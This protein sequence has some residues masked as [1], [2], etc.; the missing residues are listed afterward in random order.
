MTAHTFHRLAGHQITE[1]WPPPWT[2]WI[3]DCGAIWESR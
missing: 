1:R 2:L 3:C